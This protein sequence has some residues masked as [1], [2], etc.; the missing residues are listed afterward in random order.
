MTI[1]LSLPSIPSLSV[2]ASPQ[3]VVFLPHGAPRFGSQS[4]FTLSG[5]GHAQGMVNKAGLNKKG[6]LEEVGLELSLHGWIRI[7][8]RRLRGWLVNDLGRM[9]LVRTCLILKSPW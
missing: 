2:S 6:F 5:A 8:L 1:A 4:C 7:R 9:S 3:A